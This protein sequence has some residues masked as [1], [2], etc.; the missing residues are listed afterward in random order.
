MVLTKFE[1]LAEE[2]DYIVVRLSKEVQRSLGANLEPFKNQKRAEKLALI[3]F[4]L[5]ESALTLGD[6]AEWI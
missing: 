5:R 4:Q 3:V 2:L 6:E 1:S